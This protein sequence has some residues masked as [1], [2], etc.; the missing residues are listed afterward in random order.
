MLFTFYDTRTYDAGSYLL[1]IANMMRSLYWKNS[2]HAIHL[3]QA[4]QS[5]SRISRI[6]VI[7]PPLAELQRHVGIKQVSYVF[8]SINREV[9]YEQRKG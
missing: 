1:L 2:Y 9:F 7:P 3:Q 6:K 5:I 4:A 8:L